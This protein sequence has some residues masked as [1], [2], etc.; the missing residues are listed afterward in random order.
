MVLSQWDWYC[1]W[2]LLLFPAPLA[3]CKVKGLADMRW[4]CHSAF[5][6][7]RRKFV[8]IN[9]NVFYL[10]NIN[11]IPKITAAQKQRWNN[12]DRWQTRFQMKR[13]ASASFRLTDIFTHVFPPFQID[14]KRT[15]HMGLWASYSKKLTPDLFFVWSA[16]LLLH[17]NPLRFFKS[18]DVYT[19]RKNEQCMCL[20]FL[21]RIVIKKATNSAV[22]NTF[23]TASSV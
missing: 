6:F 19:Q 10:Y 16:N 9:Q 8:Y 2:S 21:A 14:K 1:Y 13:K 18:Y 22:P 15:L 4:T 23:I 20:L 7:C 11:V 3:T 17:E 12:W 5:V